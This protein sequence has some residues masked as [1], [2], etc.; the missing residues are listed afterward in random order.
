MER[1]KAFFVG[2]RTPAY[3]DKLP[4]QLLLTCRTL[5]GGYLY[6]ITY[7]IRDGIVNPE[8]QKMQIAL[9]VAAIV[10]LIFGFIFMYASLRNLVIGRYVGGKLDLGDRPSGVAD[11]DEAIV[12]AISGTE[13]EPELV[14]EETEE[15]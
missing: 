8:S 3:S 15:E 11:E 2:D 10:F 6:Y 9:I 5:V 12:G 13:D 14:V 4:T 7:G 1:I